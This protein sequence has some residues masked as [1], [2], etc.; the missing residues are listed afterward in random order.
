[1]TDNMTDA[2][3]LREAIAQYEQQLAQVQATLSVTTQEADRENLL[4][5]QS[6]IQELITLTKES[7]QGVETSSED[8]D[9]D[10]D[11]D[12]VDGDDDMDD[13]LA[14]E[15]ALFKAEL[16]KTSND[17]ENK[18]QDKQDDGASNNIEDELRQLEGMKCR[19]PHGSSWGGI[20]YHNAM[21]CSVYQNDRTKI[22]NM[23]DIKVRVLFLNP[24]HKEMLPCPYYLDGKCKF[25]D[26]DCRF[27]HG[28]LVSL[29]S[30]QEYREPDFQSIKMGS[31]VLAK[32]KNQLWH[33][34]IVL[35]M[36]EKEGDVFRIKFEA[37][38]NITE[39]FLPDLLPLDDADLEMSDTS[40]D[41][42]GESDST[43]Y[44][45]EEVVHKS[46]LTVESNTPLGNWEKYTRGIGSK[47]MAQMGYIAGTGLGKHSDGRVE[48]VE[49]TVLPAGKSLDHCMELRENAGGD[50][51]LFSVERK[52]RKQQQ[53]LEQQREKQYQREKEREENNIFNFI[54]ATLG[55]K[56]KNE[57]QKNISK[58]KNNLK[59]ESNRQLNVA[60]LQ[61][62]E[63]ILRLERESTKLKESLTRHAKGSVHYNNIIM[64][65][66]EK[67]KELVS[68]RASEKSI[69]VEQDQRKNRAKLSIF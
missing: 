42:D 48:P 44:S 34:C 6:D 32:Q 5:L 1:M 67:Q 28:E 8:L 26:E 7:L 24:T 47:L 10:D 60:S 14:K 13:P 3:S 27:S 30:I 9:D 18:E 25:S 17:S 63:T 21:I 69:A 36:P 53:K 11:D 49:A 66:N 33:R 65:Y 58:G 51:N 38:G 4:S 43:E 59:T 54:N 35:K 19:A 39:V 56:P 41:S 46:L 37:S 2:E 61:I 57:I 68:L 50:K 52:M 45:K 15:Y 40:D 22:K 62:G 12:D 23:Q 29:S 55:D 64:K 31:R 16:E 20:G